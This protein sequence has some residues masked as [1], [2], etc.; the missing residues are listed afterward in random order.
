MA[1]ECLGTAKQT[2][3]AGIRASLVEMLRDI[4]ISQNAVNT[5]DGIKHFHRFQTGESDP[6]AD[7]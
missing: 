1:A 6:E 4:L 3:D 7:N 2:F 5:M